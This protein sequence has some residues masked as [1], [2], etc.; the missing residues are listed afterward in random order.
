MYRK[1]DI[2]KPVCAYTSKEKF[3]V[4]SRHF[5]RLVYESALHDDNYVTFTLPFQ[6]ICHF[7][8]QYDSIT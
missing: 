8:F 1:E 3:L 6:F 2:I 4:L 5:S 7:I